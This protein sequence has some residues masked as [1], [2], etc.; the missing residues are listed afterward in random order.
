MD[1]EY[2]K[3]SNNDGVTQYN[4][5]TPQAFSHFT[6]EKSEHELVVVDVQGVEDW[7]TDP[8]IHTHV[9]SKIRCDLQLKSHLEKQDQRSKIRF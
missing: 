2:K 8:Q 9:R 6:Y 3:Y 4:R 7:Y 1:G 5:N